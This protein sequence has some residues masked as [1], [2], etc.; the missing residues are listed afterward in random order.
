MKPGDKEEAPLWLQA[1]VLVSLGAIVW[2]RVSKLPKGTVIDRD[3]T[4]ISPRL[5]QT[6]DRLDVHLKANRTRLKSEI[7][8]TFKTKAKKG[9]YDDE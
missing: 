1:I 5:R 2:W 8:E 6:L 3:G 7:D 9:D 4:P